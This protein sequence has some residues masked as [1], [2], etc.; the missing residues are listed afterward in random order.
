MTVPSWKPEVPYHWVS[1]Q[2]HI[3]HREVPVQFLKSIAVVK[4][5]ICFTLKS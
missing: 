2:I 4:V 5:E 1:V 3:R